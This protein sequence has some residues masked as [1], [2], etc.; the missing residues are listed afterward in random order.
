[1]ARVNF[2]YRSQKDKA[3]LKVRLQI[4]RDAETLKKLKAKAKK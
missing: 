2:L 1:M 3:N 4:K